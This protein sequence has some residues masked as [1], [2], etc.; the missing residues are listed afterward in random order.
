MILPDQNI[1]NLLVSTMHNGNI[2]KYFGTENYAWKVGIIQKSLRTLKIFL[3]R[4][5]V[6]KHC[7]N[8]SKQN[9]PLPLDQNVMILL[10]SN[11]YNGNI[12]TFWYK[13][14]MHE[15]FYSSKIFESFVNFSCMIFWT[16]MFQCPQQI[17]YWP[18][19][20][21]TMNV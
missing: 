4:Y 1:L 16:K 17:Y 20:F 10:V 2:K 13:K 18:T 11:I 5:F 6:P 21:N 19:M 7:A 15:D 9:V 12:E 8:T 14:I 3:V